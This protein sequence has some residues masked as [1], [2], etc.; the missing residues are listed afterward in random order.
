MAVTSRSDVLY[1]ADFRQKL[2]P[3]LGPGT[4]SFS[5]AGAARLL[6]AEGRY[7]KLRRDQYR[8]RWTPLNLD[9]AGTLARRKG[10]LLEKGVTPTTDDSVDFSSGSAWGRSFFDS[11]ESAPSIFDDLPS[12]GE[13]RK[14]TES[15]GDG[16]PRI[17][18]GTATFTGDKETAVLIVERTGPFDAGDTSRVGV[19]DT[20]TVSFPFRA[21]YEWDADSVSI[22]DGSGTAVREV[23]TESGPNGGRVVLIA[24]TGSGTSGNNRELRGYSAWD[25]NSTSI[26]HYCDHTELAFPTSPI[27]YVGSPVARQGEEFFVS[28][29][30]YQ[31]G[32]TTAHYVDLINRHFPGNNI[33]PRIICI[34]DGSNPFVRTFLDDTNE[35][36][37]RLRFFDKDGNKYNADCNVGTLKPGDRLEVV[38]LLDPSDGQVRIVARSSS[39]HTGSDQGTPGSWTTP[40][41]LGADNRYVYDEKAS[42]DN[43][44]RSSLIFL[45]H[46][47]IDATQLDGGTFS[48]NADDLMNEMA[49]IHVGPNGG[50]VSLNT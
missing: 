30:H 36:Q 38:L 46:H 5:R 35:G 20:D 27:P 32:L 50:V 21:E 1:A 48:A 41:D 49:G 37:V 12:G 8:G 47:A 9:E 2:A 31:T 13:A 29:G 39:G 14:V 16:S 34:G 25:G 42:L 26:L 23:L 10:L 15:G 6:T 24:V 17:E 11:E 40:T 3:L 43:G 19:L 22:T 44:Q 18:Q 45:R 28:P 7:A 33:F 4:P